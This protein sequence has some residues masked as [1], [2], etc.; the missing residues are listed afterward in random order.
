MYLGFR[1]AQQRPEQRSS[2]EFFAS[3]LKIYP[4]NANA[5]SGLGRGGGAS[6]PV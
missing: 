1:A 3:S 5:L 2:R 6:A 4:R